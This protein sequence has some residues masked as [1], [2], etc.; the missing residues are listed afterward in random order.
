MAVFKNILVPTDFSKHAEAG[1]PYAVELAKRSNGKLH[2]LHVFHENPGATLYAGLVIGGSAWLEEARHRFDAQLKE[3]AEEIQ[4]R[5]GVKVIYT[6]VAG[7][8]VHEIVNYA[9]KSNVDVIVMA[10]HGHGVLQHAL[11]GSTAERV[12]RLATKP[13]LTIRPAEKAQGKK[14]N[15]KHILVATDFSS[16]SNAAWPLAAAIAKENGAS[17]TLAYAVEPN[18]Y[19]SNATSSEGIGVDVADWMES[20]RAEGRTQIAQAVAKFKGRSK[21]QVDG[22]LRE[23]RAADEIVEAAEELGADLIV[24]ATHGYTGLSHLVFGSVA[25]R[26]VRISSVPVLAVKP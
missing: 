21:L 2:L 7:H 14:L 8:P 9:N 20:V 5:H 22:I 4:R 19:Y 24:I 17:V 13:L 18:V 10:T 1:V 23:G 6:Q 11:M 26:V 15:F 3:K 16:N 12:A 25:E